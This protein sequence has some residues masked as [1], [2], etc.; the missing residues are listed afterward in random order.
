ML[1]LAINLAVEYLHLASNDITPMGGTMWVH[2]LKDNG[3]VK[4]SPI[5]RIKNV[6]GEK[7]KQKV[8]KKKS[9]PVQTLE[10]YQH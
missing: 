2:N 3:Q 5:D 4:S 1:I 7:D 10:T 6:L 9:S 8:V